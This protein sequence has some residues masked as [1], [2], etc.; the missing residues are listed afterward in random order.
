M[1]AV[2]ALAMT[3]T[4]VY[5]GPELVQ[6]A[7]LLRAQSWNLDIA[8]RRPPMRA[9]VSQALKTRTPVAQQFWVA[10]PHV[11]F[12]LHLRAAGSPSQLLLC[13]PLRRGHNFNSSRAPP[14]V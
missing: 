12:A 7:P 1:L 3:A 10:S 4:A 11:G 14:V 8:A 2:I 9:Q 6:S 13:A 5:A